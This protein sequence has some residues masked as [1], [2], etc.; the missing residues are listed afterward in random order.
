MSRWDR[1][2][3]STVHLKGYVLGAVEVSPL[4]WAAVSTKNVFMCMCP[5]VWG[6]VL[7]ELFL[8]LLWSLHTGKMVSP[9][10]KPPNFLGPSLN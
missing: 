8:V 6:E 9:C 5:G 3:A 10:E 4:D 1:S 2:I 7:T